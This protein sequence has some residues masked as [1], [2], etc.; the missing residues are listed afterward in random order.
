MDDPLAS[1][2][3]MAHPHMS[4]PGSLSFGR[5]HPANEETAFKP[6]NID[7]S[8]LQKFLI[9]LARQ[10]EQLQKENED[11]REEVHGLKARSGTPGGSGG[12]PGMSG[13]PGEG[14]W[15]T[16]EFAGVKDRL[17]GIERRA[18]ALW[19]EKEGS[20]E[21]R[22]LVHRLKNDLDNTKSMA[23]DTQMATKQNTYRA[24]ELDTSTGNIK[25]ALGA[26]NDKISRLE[27]EDKR[28]VEERKDAS[29][30]I[31]SQVSS[32]WDQIRHVENSLSQRLSLAETSQVA[33]LQEVDEMKEVANDVIGRLDETKRHVS[34]LE[35]KLESFNTQVAAAISPLHN[36]LM[37]VQLR[38]EEIMESKQDRATAIT[39]EDV[40]VATSR[41]VDH[42][43]RRSDSI[44]KSIG[45]MEE[46]VEGLNDVKANKVDVVMVADLATLMKEQAEQLDGQL[47]EYQKENAKA[48]NLKAD[49]EEVMAME[50][51]LGN[52]TNTLE[53]AILKGLK[54]ISDKVS[55]ALAEKLDIARF[56]EFKV[57]I[58]AILADIED[59]LRDW[60]PMASGMKAPLDGSGAVGG[61]SCLCCDS[62][63]R[64]V[65]DLQSMGF[66]AGDR[67]FAPEKLPNTEGLLPSI[68]RSP[69][70]AAHTNAKLAARKKDM[71]QMMRTSAHTL[72]E[73]LPTV[74]PAAA[75]QGPVSPGIGNALNLELGPMVV[76]SKSP[77]KVDVE[78][79]AGSIQAG[80]IPDMR[81]QGRTPSQAKASGTLSR[82][83][84]PW[85]LDQHQSMQES[86]MGT[87]HSQ[88]HTPLT[89]TGQDIGKVSRAASS[90]LLQQQTQQQDQQAQH[91]EQQQ[92]QGQ[93]PQHQHPQ[94]Q[95]H[96]PG[97]QGHSMPGVLGG[98]EDVDI[99]E[100]AKR[101]AR[102][103][104]ASGRDTLSSQ[105]S[106]GGAG[107]GDASRPRTHN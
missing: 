48:L 25:E 12:G 33:T 69:E 57:Q 67:V 20:E 96:P 36:T 72:P 104:T 97:G 81:G 9:A 31:E 87:H 27:Q 40:N 39:I 107:K 23:Q 56:D 103:R 98:M 65:R 93:P 13:G 54:V 7:V 64:S 38:T 83:M 24:Q 94:Q 37:A 30:K 73:A 106:A 16:Q 70:L 88:K 15:V 90:Q 21:L 43:D 46:R 60:S 91:Q 49:K 26:I 75:H 18:E 42:A 32:I 89:L 53:A 74:S 77:G 86:L 50:V 22:V 63:V 82:G 14:H 29:S 47:A 105:G 80:K 66:P 2:A 41:A 61:S 92:H 100:A 3:Q 99:A 17:D 10:V 85:N 62:R 59:R 68:H 101:A 34:A 58:R 4:D 84:T 1:L 6:F 8:P 28:A 11:L 71:A 5:H 78:T 51:R 79:V 52:R 55:A 44:M 95:V 45:A 102:T 35:S 19:H 76:N